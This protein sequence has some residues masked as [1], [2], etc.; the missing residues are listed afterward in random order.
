MSAPSPSPF[1]SEFDLAPELLYLNSGTHSLTPRAVLDAVAREERGYEANPTAKLMTAWGRL[2]EVQKKLGTFLN[3]DPQC[4]FLRQNVT[5]AMN[6]F[7]LG[8]PLPAGSEILL[9]DVEYPAIANICRY[10][11]ERDGLTVRTFSLPFSE[12]ALRPETSLLVLSHVVTGTGEILPVAEIGAVARA[13]GVLLAVDGAHAAGA[14]DLD[15]RALADL[16]FYGSNLHKWMMGPKGTGFGWASPRRHQDLRPLEAGWATFESPNDY[17]AFGDGARFP[18]RMLM[19]GSR[20]FAPFFA[21]EDTLAF[22]DRHGAENIRARL[23]SLQAR[24]EAEVAAKL[25][26]P[27][28]SPPLDGGRR[29]P[30]TTFELPARLEAE[31]YGLMSRLLKERGLQVGVPRVK[32][33]WRLRLSPHVYNTEADISRAADILR[34]AG[35]AS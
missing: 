12:D 27:L 11:A 30:L 18:A 6:A 4:L 14:L 19:Q 8:I 31:G 32:G 16:D 25:G 29:G 5:E 10:R 35:S 13:R 15:F 33:R 26:W 2:W 23:R 17:A 1:L 3:A 24:L 34:S 21:I 9:S 22:W 7:I 20:N 28:L